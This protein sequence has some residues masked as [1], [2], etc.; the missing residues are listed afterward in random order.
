MTVTT[1]VEPPRYVFDDELKPGEHLKRRLLAARPSY[2]DNA[3]L[4]LSICSCAHRISRNP[5][6]PSI[7]IV[8][9]IAAAHM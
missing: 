5:S 1:M 4:N 7:L 9:S 8:H 2:R 3:R 6:L